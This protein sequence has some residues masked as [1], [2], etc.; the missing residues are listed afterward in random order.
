MDTRLSGDV[1]D[2]LYLAR[3]IPYIVPK[4]PTNF[5]RGQ[6]GI[7]SALYTIQDKN[8]R[9]R[10]TDISTY[11]KVSAPNVIKLINDL[12]KMG[13]IKKTCDSDDRRAVLVEFT[14]SGKEILEKGL[15]DF[16]SKVSEKLSAY[17]DNEWLQLIKMINIAYE[18]IEQ[19]S[20]EMNYKF[21]L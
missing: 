6:L 21:K 14:E 7:L 11:L 20:K 17:D 16:Y 8:G 4:L 1:I 3:R 12:V 10:I 9:A 19:T 13:F 15:L 2:A 5:K 18:M